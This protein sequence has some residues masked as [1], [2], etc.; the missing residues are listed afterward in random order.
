MR[1]KQQNIKTKDSTNASIMN[2]RIQRDFKEKIQEINQLWEAAL[3][4][5]AP[6]NRSKH[7]QELPTGQT[8][9]KLM[10]SESESTINSQPKINKIRYSF[11]NPIMKSGNE[12]NEEKDERD[13]KENVSERGQILMVL[14]SSNTLPVIP[15][16]KQ[17]QISLQRRRV[18]SRKIP[19]K[20]S[21]PPVIE[22]R[23]RPLSA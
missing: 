16:V 18:R 6:I 4:S 19:L 3:K 14:G 13:D 9:S 2:I 21:L 12:E 1:S 8:K 22:S 7:F 5:I 23:H 10:R 15:L 17:P 11:F 20:P